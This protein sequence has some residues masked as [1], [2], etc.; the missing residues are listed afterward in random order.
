MV[1]MLVGEQDGVQ[2]FETRAKGLRAKIR[3]GVDQHM[4][5]AVTHQ[6]GRAQALVP[7]IGGSAYVAMAAD[8]RHT[9]AG[10]GAKYGDPDGTLRHSGSLL[11]GFVG[12]LH[13]AEPQ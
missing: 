8:G 1:G 2:A 12:H 4:V 9:G 11:L 6:D 13:V 7:R 5:A 10:A 3:R